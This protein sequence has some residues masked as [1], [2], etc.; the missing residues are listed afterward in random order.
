[1][2]KKFALIIL[3]IVSFASCSYASDAVPGDVIVVLR[4]TSGYRINS[5][6]SGGIKAMSAVQSFT[7]ATGVNVI[8]TYDALSE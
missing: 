7:K 2:R 3:C 6:S 5:A 4:N 1:M 8:R